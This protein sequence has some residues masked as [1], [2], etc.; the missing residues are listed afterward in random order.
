MTIAIEP[1]VLMGEHDVVTLADQWT[2]V[3]KDGKLT[4]H[5]EHTILITED[6]PE[7]LTL[8]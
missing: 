5:C 1:M 8:L 4:A 2:V 7:V 6:G 3:S